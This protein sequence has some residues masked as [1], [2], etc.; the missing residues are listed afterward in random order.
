MAQTKKGLHGGA[1]KGAGRKPTG[2]KTVTLSFSLSIEVA[3][4][5]LGFPQGK[6]SKMVDA[7]LRKVLKVK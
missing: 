7:A 2:S 3:E 1:R 6:Q 4:V 5:I